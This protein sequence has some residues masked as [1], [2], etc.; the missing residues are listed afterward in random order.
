MPFAQLHY[1]CTYLCSPTGHSAHLDV[2]VEAYVALISLDFSKAFDT[3]SHYALASNLSILDV[4]DSIYNLVICFLNDRSHVTRFA[5]QTSV[6]A[7]INASVVQGLLFEHDNAQLLV[8]KSG[9]S[10]TRFLSHCLHSD[11]KALLS[12]HSELD[13]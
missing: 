10:Y 1:C 13:R 5:G 11:E 9:A 12:D 4:P 6:I 3:V 7:Y 8:F 2:H